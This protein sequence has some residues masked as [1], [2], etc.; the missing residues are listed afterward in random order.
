MPSDECVNPMRY[1][2]LGCDYRTNFLYN[3]KRHIKVGHLD[4]DLSIQRLILANTY[5]GTCPKCKNCIH[6]KTYFI[7]THFLNCKGLGALEC[8]FCNKEF[9]SKAS[10]CNHRKICKIRIKKEMDEANKKQIIEAS[11]KRQLLKDTAAKI[12]PEKPLIHLVKYNDTETIF[13]VDH[14]TPSIYLSIINNPEINIIM[15]RFM[16]S[17]YSRPENRCFRRYNK[18]SRGFEVYTGSQ[19]EFKDKSEYSTITKAI[20]ENLITFMSFAKKEKAYRKIIDNAVYTKSLIEML[21]CIAGD[22]ISNN[23]AFTDDIL[24]SYKLMH[25]CVCNHLL[26][27][28]PS[29]KDKD[30]I[31]NIIDE[32]RFPVIV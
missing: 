3:F 27:F 32:V 30:V 21:E 22:G 16:T 20:V 4:L 6:S 18:N 1:N 10:K 5:D 31:I 8:E 13:M 23:E 14:I 12:I 19:W 2:C 29:K 26:G 11:E 9:S 24:N 17:I 28:I 25:K 15:S 7:N